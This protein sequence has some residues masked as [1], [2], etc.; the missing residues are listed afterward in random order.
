MHDALQSE[1]TAGAAGQQVAGE[2]GP[3][4]DALMPE[5]ELLISELIIAVRQ[6]ACWCAPVPPL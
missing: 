3:R 1:H 2:G 5:E 4:G 6:R